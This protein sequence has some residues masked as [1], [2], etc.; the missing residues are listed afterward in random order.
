LWPFGIFCGNLGLFSP[1][2]GTLCQE[3]SGNPGLHWH[4]KWSVSEFGFLSLAVKLE[5][6]GVREISRSPAI[7]F[8]T[9]R[10]PTWVTPTYVPV[11]ANQ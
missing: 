8:Q 6:V 4:E 2:F 1:R 10:L 11:Q 7:S 9:H 5:G 3:K